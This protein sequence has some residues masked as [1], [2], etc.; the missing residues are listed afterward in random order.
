MWDLIG[1]VV[2]SKMK[3]L[4]FHLNSCGFHRDGCEIP[5]EWSNDFAA[6]VVDATRTV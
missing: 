1:M 6:M 2:D 3:Y 5:L 4:G